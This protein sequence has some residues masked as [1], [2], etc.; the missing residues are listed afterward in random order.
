MF[1]KFGTKLTEKTEV[2]YILKLHW[3]ELIMP[4]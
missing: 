1:S 4:S 3:K 2:A